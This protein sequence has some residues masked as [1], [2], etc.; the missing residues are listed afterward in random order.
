MDKDQEALIKAAAYHFKPTSKV[1]ILSGAGM[2]QESGIPTFRG[3]GGL[4]EKYDPEECATA[5][6]IR[7]RPKK[8]WQMHDELRQLLA[9]HEPNPGHF[10]IAELEELFENVTVITQN[11]D[12]YHQAAGSTK[13]IEVHGN[14]WRVRCTAENRSWVDMT[15]PYAELP[16]KC[17]CGADLRP[18]VVFFNE[19]LDS[20]VLNAA[21]D[22]TASADVFLVI[23][24]SYVV[25]PA[26]YL[27]VMAKEN[28]AVLININQEVTDLY[29]MADVS[30][31]G[32]S[33]ELLPK[34]ITLLKKK[35]KK[36]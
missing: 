31:V 4:W 5:E 6:A 14:A 2:S 3:K 10:A 26:A 29:A 25:V 32:K 24:T 15:V 23:G 17:E 34:L 1:V 13:V 33:G 30:I 8:V 16:P 28:G 9:S 20:K 11:V 22:E 27:P 18:D 19:Q 36:K 21:F 35:I 12:N 7:H